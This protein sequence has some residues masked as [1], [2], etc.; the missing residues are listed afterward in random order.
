[1]TERGLTVRGLAGGSG[2]PVLVTGS[3]AVHPALR[4]WLER[5]QPSR[6]VLL[7]GRAALSDQVEAEVPGP[8]RIAGAD[9]AATAA[10]VVAEL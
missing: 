4:A 5:E 8:E 1:M 3:E 9:R 10:E 6:T 7:G 2:I